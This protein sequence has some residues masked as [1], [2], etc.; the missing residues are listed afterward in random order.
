[1]LLA[2]LKLGVPMRV[3]H[4]NNQGVMMAMHKMIGKSG[5]SLVYHGQGAEID[6]AVGVYSQ[7]TFHIMEAAWLAQGL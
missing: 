7:P 2:S 4:G 6:L 1:M 3:L 5:G